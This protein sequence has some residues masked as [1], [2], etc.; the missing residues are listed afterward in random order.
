M[1][2]DDRQKDWNDTL[3][4]SFQDIPIV[5]VDSS[6]HVRHHNLPNS[7]VHIAKH[8]TIIKC[9]FNSKTRKHK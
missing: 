7:I 1:L 5:D 4:D 9:Q 3:S 6:L 2:A 8:W